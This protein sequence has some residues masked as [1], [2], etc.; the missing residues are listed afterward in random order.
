MKKCKI[1][2]TRQLLE[3]DQNYIINGLRNMVG[4]VFMIITPDAYDEEGICKKITG[5]DVLL[6]PYVTKK[7]L[8]KANNVKLIQIPWSGT[9]TFNFDAMEGFNIPVCNSHSNVNAVAE[10]G[11]GL[12]LDLVKKISYHDRKM[13]QCNWNRDEVPLNLKSS[14]LSNMTVC[15]LGYGRIGRKIGKLLK[16]FGAT[17]IGVSNHSNMCPEVDKMYKSQDWIDAVS[18]ADLCICT[19]PL[20]DKTR[21]QINASTIKHFKKGCMIVNIS[22][23]EIF[24]DNTIYNALKE[25]YIKGFAADVWWNSPKRG[26]SQSSASKTNKYEEL[27]N[28]VL[29]PH[30]AGFIEGLLPHLDDAIINI[31]N[32]IE[33]KPLINVV[34][35]SEKY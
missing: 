33:K 24:D 22:R 27:D 17:L 16:A 34:N 13:R 32:F 10:M 21:N 8:N 31:A 9:D 29:S 25:G 35:I 4:D 19:L 26:E 7:I 6:G 20:T 1:L 2:I 18:E 23:A 28:V 14:M 11:I 5:V 15:I 30:R 12:I 3:V